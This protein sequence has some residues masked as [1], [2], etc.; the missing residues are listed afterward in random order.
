MK[1]LHDPLNN[2]LRNAFRQ[3]ALAMLA[4]MMGIA[5]AQAPAEQRTSFGTGF[6]ISD[7]H[8]LTAE[9]IISGKDVLWIGPIEG[10]WIKATL[11]KSS[12]ELDLALLS[13]DIR[14]KPMSI[15][16]WEEVPI[17]V[18]V[19]VIGYPQPKM[20]GLSKKITQGIVNG[21][22]SDK[23]GTAS[24]RLFQLS[25]E[26][27]KGNSGGPVIAA[28]GSVIG[29]VLNKVDA[30]SFAE[31]SR[32]LT[33]NVNY[34]LKSQHLL[35]FLTN[36]PA[37]TQGKTFSLKTVLRPYQVFAQSEGS[38]YAVLGRSTKD[39][40]VNVNSNAN[41]NAISNSSKP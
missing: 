41:S 33:V 35:E 16:N 11:V 40:N 25:A 30:L 13:A 26:V 34:A 37:Q 21:N 2:C 7:T 27:N 32:D 14:A 31:K 3:M 23:E 1:R 8:I 6:A 17:G 28:D 15:A 9:H 12:V 22:R 29:M 19:F 38:V 20:Q 10:K 36:T 24:S 4:C 18:E 39:A 5:F